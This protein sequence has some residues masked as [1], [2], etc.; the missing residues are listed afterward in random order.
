MKGNRNRAGFTGRA[1]GLR[2]QSRLRLWSGRFAQGKTPG[3]AGERGPVQKG[4]GTT[5]R[6]ERRHTTAGQSPYAA[7][8]FR[9]TTSEI[10]NPDGAA[11][12]R[13]ENVEGPECSS[14][15]P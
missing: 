3:A 8:D 1:C 14:H 12:F 7:I 9:L 13:L 4:R 5:M 2:G 10:R 15:V 6:I 11:G